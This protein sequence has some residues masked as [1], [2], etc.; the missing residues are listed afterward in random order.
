MNQ[1]HRILL[2]DDHAGTRQGLRAGLALQPDLQVVGEADTWHSA[3]ALAQELRPALMVLDLN[4]PDGNGWTLIERLKAAQALPATLVLSVCDEQVYARNLL[5]AGA[6][7]YLMKDEPLGQ[8]LQAIRQI[9]GGR[10]VASPVLTNQFIQEALG[11]AEDPL[12]SEPAALL[13]A[14]SDRELQIFTLLGRGLRNKEIAA[15]LGLS[16]KSVSTYKVR[17]FKK[18]DVGTTLELIERF[19]Q[20]GPSAGVPAIA[21]TARG[22]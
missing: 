13:D 20:F 22:A 9:I 15:M 12:P 14:L 1:P 6:R 10:L 4:L 19:R 21:T 2:V 18:L 7:G 8:I 5:R 11:C 17:L 3:L 16:E